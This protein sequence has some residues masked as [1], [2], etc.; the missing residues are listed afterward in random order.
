[1]SL[2]SQWREYAYGFDDR[3]PEGK[4]YIYYSVWG[5]VS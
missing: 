5:I 2:L 3:T 4:H 1:M